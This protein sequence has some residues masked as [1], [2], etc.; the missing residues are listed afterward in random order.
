[1]KK[2]YIPTWLLLV[3]V[4]L[5]SCNQWLDVRPEDEIDE[6]DLFLDG[7]GYRN[8]LNGVYK[9]LAEYDLYGRNLSW[10]IVDAL[11]QCYDYTYT[12]GDTEDMRFGAAEYDWENTT[13]KPRIGQIWEKAYN[14]VANCNNILLNIQ[15]ESPEK[16]SGKEK[17]QKM[18]WGE[19]LALRAFIQFDMLRLF[20]AAPAAKPE[21]N[22]I[23]YI[24]VYPSYVSQR[25]STGE[26][27]QRII[28]DLKAAQPLVY[29]FDSE[30][31]F[32]VGE[33]F[34]R[35]GA[36]DKRFTKSR[37]FRLNYY[38]ITGLLAR[39]YL[40]GE[41]PDS[42]YQQAKI[43]IA[44]QD[45]KNVFSFANHIS[46]GDRKFYSDVIAGLY[47]PKLTD[48]EKKVNDFTNPDNAHYLTLLNVRD[49][50][51]TDL[52]EDGDYI[53]QSDDDRYNYWIEDY[54]LY[55]YNFIPIKYREETKTTQKSEVS[56]KL[57]PLLRMSEVYYIAAEACCRQNLD[58]AIG[59][60]CRVKEGR[61]LSD[62]AI[63]TLRNSIDT[64]DRLIREVIRDAR[65][66]LVGEGQIFYIYKRRNEAI[67]G[68][69]NKT[70]PPSEEK[71]VLPL[72]ESENTA[73]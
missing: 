67:P 26:C 66:E 43:I 52:S 17:E 55:G 27:L 13:L 4:F 25:L 29:A 53:L 15:D 3:P 36:G 59:Y 33:R 48:W 44:Y 63:N 70:I 8:A 31:P 2:Y 68:K 7:E 1:M 38:A 46:A 32:N 21:K 35:P 64:P 39:A 60:L 12:G 37:G 11:G 5:L 50:Y 6:K 23:P 62:D 47:A 49:I 42:A 28:A 22:Y 41:Q 34:D 9:A 19:A 51:D 45:E 58:E 56:N 10:G 57:V 14:A 69:N 61:G 54:N 71:F 18:I 72:P 40:Y 65:R 30:Q 20:A 16:F 73:I 24:D